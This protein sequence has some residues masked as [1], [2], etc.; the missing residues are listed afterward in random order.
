M[1]EVKARL[2]HRAVFI[3]EEPINCELTIT[4]VDPKS[5]T[6]L[7]L[8]LANNAQRK[9]LQASSKS[10]ELSKTIAWGSAQIYCQCDINDRKVKV[11]VSL[12]KQLKHIISQTSFKPVLGNKITIYN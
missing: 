3:P 11:P 1:L 6:S 10:N 4:N 12:Q 7:E 2:L 8:K 5:K 9:L